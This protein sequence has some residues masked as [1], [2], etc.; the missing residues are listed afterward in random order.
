MSDAG[1]ADEEARPAGEVSVIAVPLAAK[2]LAKKLH[3]VSKRAAASKILK[4]GVK[5]VVKAL[6]KGDG[7]KGCVGLARRA[8]PMLLSRGC[9][10]AGLASGARARAHA[11]PRRSVAPPPP[12]PQPLHHCGRHFTH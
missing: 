11:P 6:R 2:K 4:R 7:F 9:R 3:K 1:G 12:L 10:A 8:V 5:E